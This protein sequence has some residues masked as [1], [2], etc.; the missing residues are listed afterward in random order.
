VTWWAWLLLWL[1][2]VVGALGVFALLGRSLWRKARALV[3]TLGAASERLNALTERLDAAPE[4][5]VERAE[6]AVFVDPAAVR[7]E[8][9]F[10]RRAARHRAR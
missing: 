1:L 2:L 4:R 8:R 10:G 3:D 5:A 9:A 7:L 6:L